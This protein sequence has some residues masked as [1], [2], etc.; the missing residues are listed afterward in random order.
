MI[1]FSVY[2]SH[3][4]VLIGNLTSFRHN[5]LNASSTHAIYHIIQGPLRNIIP[6][7]KDSRAQVTHRLELALIVVNISRHDAP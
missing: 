5:Y 6:R 7:T 4:L 1:C 3:T 2:G